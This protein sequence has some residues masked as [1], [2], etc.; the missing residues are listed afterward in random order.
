MDDYNIDLKEIIKVLLKKW[1]VITL[2]TACGVAIAMLISTFLLTPMFSA[3]VS[4]YVSNISEN[5]TANLNI[6]DITASQKMV[7]TCI[8]ITKSESLLNEVA[9]RDGTDYSKAQLL[10]MTK[11][12][13]V[14]NTELL[15]IVVTTPDPIVSARIANTYLQVLPGIVEK[16]INGGL[17]SPL[18]K[19]VP[20]SLPSFPNI[21][22]NSAIGGLLGLM[23]SILA[24]FLIKIIDA[25]VE[26]EEDLQKHYDIPILGV[27]PE[28][29]YAKYGQEYK[30]AE[31]AHHKAAT[32]KK[33]SSLKTT[34]INQDTDF[35]I[36]E[37]Y[38]KIR[39]NLIFALAASDSK[40]V[41]ISSPLAKEGKSTTIANL[42]ISM[43]N[44]N[45]KVLL[46]DAD[47]RKPSIYKLFSLPNTK[48]LS[49]VLGGFVTLEET[50]QIDVM[51]HLDILVSGQIPPNPSELIGS[52]PMGKLLDRLDQFY[53]Y[54]FIDTPPINIVTDTL[55]LSKN[56]NNIMLV[57]SDGE[58]RHDQLQKCI[59][60]IEFSKADIS[61]IIVNK[62]TENNVRY[63]YKHKYKYKTYKA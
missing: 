52:K 10:S 27:I 19:S 26:G 42:A 63:K 5:T 56:V 22:L 41:C 24:L 38:A 57:V 60:A 37:G 54:I 50:I 18:D 45:A 12:M 17:V 23:L 25:R 3:R 11:S 1:W 13:A 15:E 33:T 43:A 29:S 31:D 6:N 34:L 44:N 47:F 62:S 36:R 8:A 55:A 20:P 28:F 32:K 2:A 21:P 51:P 14:N 49:S 39:T 61:G 30:L 7:N 53:D 48:G 9:F 4:L 46:I 59:G 16:I 35:G 58:T 40:R